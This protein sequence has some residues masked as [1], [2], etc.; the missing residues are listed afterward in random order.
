MPLQLPNPPPSSINARN[1]MRAN[2]GSDTGPERAVRAALRAAGLAGYRL[3]WRQAPGRPD[4]AY[5]GRRVAIFV[6]GCFWHRCPRCTPPNPKAHSEFWERKF[7]LNVE[8]DARKR[9]QLEAAG[10]LV[11]VI[12]ECEVR[13]RLPDS[14][15]E[16][17][18]ALASRPGRRRSPGSVEG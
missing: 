10:W 6:H 14:V 8:R 3:N 17:A 11:L 4:I 7:A 9:A 15:A 13:E 1:T 16:V 18:R 5:P 12:W 2:R